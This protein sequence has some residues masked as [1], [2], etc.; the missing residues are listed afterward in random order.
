MS[1]LDSPPLDPNSV[2]TSRSANATNLGL[3]RSALGAGF[4]IFATVIIVASFGVWVYAFSGF[5]SQDK[6]DRFDDPLLAP[7]AE[8]ICAIAID[9]VAAMPGASE[10]ENA[11]DRAVQIR[12]TTTRYETMVNDLSALPTTTPRDSE[13]MDGWVD[14]W[15]TLLADRRS[16]AE[17]LEVD[18][19][20]QFSI[21]KIEGRERLDKRIRRLSSVNQMPSCAD[22][23]DV[24]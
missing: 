22:P 9:D 10:A 20:A 1:D 7:A 3:L 16:Y 19:Q 24:A 21:S 6:A 5:A 15:R 13:I 17:T 8:Q 14:N 12:A 2:S 23:Q 11:K 4:K 18:N